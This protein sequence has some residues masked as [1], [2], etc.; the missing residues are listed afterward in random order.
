MR[1]GLSWVSQG[2]AALFRRR[3]LAPTFARGFFFFP[4]LHPRYHPLPEAGRQFDL[5]PTLPRA[6]RRAGG[7][8]VGGCGAGLRVPESLMPFWVGSSRGDVFGSKFSPLG[9]AWPALRG[10]KGGSAWLLGS[11][12]QS[13]CD[14]VFIA[15]FGGQ[16]CAPEAASS[17]MKKIR[18][19]SIF[20]TFCSSDSRPR[21]LRLRRNNKA[22]NCRTA[23]IT[24]HT[25]F[26]FLNNISHNLNA[27]RKGR[28]CVDL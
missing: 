5:G 24:K 1:S 16:V 4:K 10:Q 20:D 3:G 21:H 25:H 15:V 27:W 17:T 19:S 23:S 7:G 26:F 9:G 8:G 22:V 28:K 18:L 2:R 14:S 13:P 6:P 11:P 12:G